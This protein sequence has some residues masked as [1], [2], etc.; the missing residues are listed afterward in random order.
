[1]IKLSFCEN[2]PPNGESFGRIP[3]WSLIYFLNYAYFD[4]LPS[5]LPFETPS[6]LWAIWA[7]QIAHSTQTIDE[8]FK[9][10]NTKE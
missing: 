5:L 10:T 3:V 1:M 9:C 7:E 8:G 6:S 4:I 2:D